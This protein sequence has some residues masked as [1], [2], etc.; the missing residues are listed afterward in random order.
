MYKGSYKNLKI[1]QKGL[2]LTKRIYFFTKNF[3]KE[4]IYALTNQLRRCSISIPSNIAEG[5]RRSSNK[6]FSNFILIARGSLAELET[7]MI[8]AESFGY[9]HKEEMNDLLDEI[10]E[11]DKMIFSFHK[12]LQT[13]NS[14]LP[15]AQ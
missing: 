7:Q 1:W 11:L 13:T 2:N 5:S 3:P 15:T 9:I 4:E 10:N 12:K 6:E 14:K 8:L